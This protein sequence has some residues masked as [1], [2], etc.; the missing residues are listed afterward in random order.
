MRI[1]ED[2]RPGAGR[3]LAAVR[4]AAAGVT[5]AELGSRLG[6]HVTTVRFHLDRLA[7][8]GLVAGRAAPS[9]GRGRPRVVYQA[10]RVPDAR[11]GMLAALADAAAGEGPAAERAQ[12]AGERW[13]EG[14]DV[15]GL[16]PVAALVAVF[17]ELGFAPAPFE[18]GLALR[19]CPFLEDARRHPEVVCGVH[20]GL[21]LG[22]ARRAGASI[23]LRPFEGGVCVLAIA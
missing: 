9:G 8:D 20:R 15:D 11:V 5:A 17:T 18:G 2:A 12:R 16:D 1:D 22:I 19:A 7:A 4:D 23:E 6:L 14:L 21:A 3:V 13:A 10:V